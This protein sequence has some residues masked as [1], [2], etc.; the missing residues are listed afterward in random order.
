MNRKSVFVFG[1]AFGSW[2]N[3]WPALIGPWYSFVFAYLL[4]FLSLA[5][6]T[7]SRGAK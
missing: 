6:E 2:L 1:I 7:Y 3:A 4:V 5:F